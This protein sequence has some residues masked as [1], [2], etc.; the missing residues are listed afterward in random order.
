MLLLVGLL[1]AIGTGAILNLTA[2][3][4]R[5]SSDFEDVGRTAVPLSESALEL[6]ANTSGTGLGV[7]SYLQAPRAEYRAL[8]DKSASNLKRFTQ[9]F[10]DA[11]R[12]DDERA[13]LA[14]IPELFEEYL[15]LGRSLMDAKDRRDDLIAR[16]AAERSSDEAGVDERL[17]SDLRGTEARDVSRFLALHTR[18]EARLDDQVQPAL[19][20]RVSTAEEKVAREVGQARRV[21][22][23]LGLTLLTI[24]LFA[25]LHLTRTTFVPLSKLVAGADALAAGNLGH[26]LVDVD[27]DEYGAL[28]RSLNRMAARIQDAFER[29]SHH[30]DELEQRIAERTEALEAMARRDTLTGLPNRTALS[31]F[32]SASILRAQGNRSSVAVLLLDLD[33]FKIVNDTIGHDQGDVLLQEVARR[34]LAEVKAHDMVA[35]LGGDEFCIVLVDLDDREHALAVARR[36]LQVLQPPVALRGDTVSAHGSIGIALYPTDADALSGL[37]KAADTAM[38]VA[39]Q[40]G[41]NRCAPYEPAMTYTLNRELKLGHELRR[42]VQLGEFELHYQPQVDLEHYGVDRVEALIRWRNPQRGLIQPDEFVPLAERLG[43]LNAI[44]EWVIDTACRQVAAWHREGLERLTVAVNVSPH[45]FESDHFTET[46]SR[47]LQETGVTG[48]SLEIEVTEST[49][50]DPG[51]HSAIAERLGRLGVRVAVDDFGAG[52]SSLSVLQRAYAHTLKLDGRFV[53]DI[54]DAPSKSVMIAAIISMALGLDLMTV[55]EGVETLEQVQILR[56]LGCRLAQGYFFSPPVAADR[57]PAIVRAG[58]ATRVPP[59]QVKRRPA[60]ALGGQA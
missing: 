19:R 27:D 47:V 42:A 48:A 9:Q 29:L 10:E 13:T 36:C 25:A 23:A 46:V 17:L 55:A 58:F 56:G 54:G 52:Y 5:I 11:G 53:R 8:V 16:I 15:T 20:Q 37:L 22:V 41:K 6:K 31:E 3:L 30:R 26:R 7:I 34:L 40:N 39:K 24:G 28:A 33:G 32:M 18:L 4:R 50:R 12:V 14:G 21:G 59:L 51:S 57:V 1:L 44:G 35:R 2:S 38:Y 60:L 43:L 45:H 49:F